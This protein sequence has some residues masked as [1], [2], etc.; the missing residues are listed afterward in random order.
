MFA[1]HFDEAHSLQP[2]NSILYFRWSQALSYEDL[3]SLDRLQHALELVKKAME[4]YAR[5][6]ILKEQG[7]LVL[8]MLNLHNAAEALEYQ[9]GF[10]DSQLRHETAEAV[11]N[12]AGNLL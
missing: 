8:K 3:A 4:C 11:S 9:R 12:I 10:V 7:K 1:C 2:S 5:E 6:K